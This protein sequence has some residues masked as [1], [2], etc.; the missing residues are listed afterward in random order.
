MPTTQQRLISGTVNGLR[1]LSVY[2]PNGQSVGSDKWEYKL[3]WLARLGE[4]LD[5]HYSR[6]TPLV[7]AGDFNVA[8]EARD[9]H[10]PEE[11]EPS[12]LFHPKAREAMTEVRSFGL[13]DSFRRHHQGPGFYSWWDYRLLSFPKNRGLRID[14]IFVTDTVRTQDSW[15]DRDQRKGKQPSDHAPILATIG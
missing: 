13:D 11:W 14:Q 3:R 7:V 4:H 6:A 10:D 9:V 12:V 8:P 2:A 15:I 1:I 5:R